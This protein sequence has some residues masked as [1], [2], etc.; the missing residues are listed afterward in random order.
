MSD[1]VSKAQTTTIS[2]SS[3]VTVKIRD[4]FYSYEYMESRNV[5]VDDETV[6]ISEEKRLLWDSVIKEV[7]DQIVELHELF[8]S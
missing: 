7:D 1:Y 2:A 4:N 3:K 8:K 6:N 5:P